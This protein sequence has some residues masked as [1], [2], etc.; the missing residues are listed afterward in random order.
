MSI[1]N[2]SE[3]EVRCEWGQHG[4]ERLAPVSDVIVIVD[5]LSF[6]TCVDIAVSRGAT[7]Y[8]FT[9][10]DARLA[11]YAR[12]LGAVAASAERLEHRLSLS[13][14]SLL[15]IVAGTRLVLPSPNGSQL[16]LSKH[17]AAVIAGCIRNAAA[18]ANYVTSHY[19]SVS[20]IPSGE[21]WPDGS[22]RPAVEDLIGAGAII[23]HLEG[24]HSPEARAAVAV[25]EDAR[26]HGLLA[27]IQ[28]CSSG[29]ELM[30]RGFIRD[31]Q[32][33]S[34]LDSSTSIPRL[35]DGAYPS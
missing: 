12:E 8:P 17:N 6:S 25:F 7:V 16:S 15:S 3:F 33:S 28:E 27:S 23:A 14:A 32:L 9:H 1:F 29:K 30:S 35:I 21:R 24:R 5:V 18:V 10:K 26:R 34:E 2:Q 4:V 19:K 20:I 11:D 22:L 13:S 31:I